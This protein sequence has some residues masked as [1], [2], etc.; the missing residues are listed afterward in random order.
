MKLRSSSIV[1][2]CSCAVFCANAASSEWPMYRGDPAL[3]GISTSTLPSKP[4]LVWSFKSGGPV[5]S[6]PVI[7]TGKVFV[8]SDDSKVYALDFT[9]GS[10]VWEFKA[11][12]PVQAPPLF[13]SNRVFVGSTEGAFFA[14]DAAT[15]IQLWK[16]G[17]EGK[18][19][20]SANFFVN[21]GKPNLLIGSY[22]FKLHCVDATTGK[23]VWTYESGNYIN[24]SPAV[25]DGKTVFGGCD[26]MLH[27]ISLADGKKIKE[28]EAGA[29]IA[30]SVALADNRAYFGHYENEFLCIDLAED[31]VLDFPR[32]RFPLFLVRRGDE[33][34]RRFW[35]RDKQLHCVNR[36]DGTSLGLSHARKSGQLAGRGGDKVVVGSDDGRVYM[37]S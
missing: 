1:F 13:Y 26:A 18:I 37:V 21:A 22:D 31:K 30:A 28:I 8:G 17:T 29:Y 9:T 3:T 35:R 7:A 33:G 14:L 32:P 36:A 5:R 11:D 10:K 23:A 12:G 34:P 15:G 2:V 20:G 16:Y 4:A 24:G 6:S 25:A 19:A 27:I